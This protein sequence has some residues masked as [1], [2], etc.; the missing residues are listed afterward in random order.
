MLAFRR[1]KADP[2]SR[3][4]DHC[5][6]SPNIIMKNILFATAA[7]IA[8]T[9]THV[10]AIEGPFKA[11]TTV[12]LELD[13]INKVENGKKKPSLKLFNGT[14]TGLQVGKTY[15]FK[16]GTNGQLTGPGGVNISYANDKRLKEL[17][18]TQYKLA[19]AV[20]YADKKT[21]GVGGINAFIEFGSV[22]QKNNKGNPVAITLTYIQADLTPSLNTKMVIY[23]FEKP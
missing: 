3:R 8:M 12:K 19:G 15:E 11:G 2:V 16:I 6:T 21:S 7:A 9:A 22:F 1:L 14:P 13:S 5:I 18:L 10:Q 23:V 4:F 20:S 17:F